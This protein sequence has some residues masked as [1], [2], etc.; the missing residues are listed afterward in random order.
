MSYR[1]FSRTWW[2]R[3]PAWPNGLEPHAGRRTPL[4]YASTESEAR[5]ICAQYNKRNEQ[6]RLSRKAEYEDA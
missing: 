2:R 4:A 3:N 1:I 5:E 6:G